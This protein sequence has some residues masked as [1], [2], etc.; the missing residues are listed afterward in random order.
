MNAHE[1]NKWGNAVELAGGAAGDAQ[2]AFTQL[3]DEAQKFFVTGER[4]PLINTLLQ[5]GVSL[6]D[7]NGQLRNQGEIF[8]ELADKTAKYGRQYQNFI[9]KQAGIS[10][11]EINYLAQSKQARE[12]NLRTAERANAVNEET[13]RKAQELQTYWR[14][15][16]IQIQAA[17]QMILTAIT[18][19]LTQVLKI[20]GDVNV[21]SEE[22]TTGLKL[23]GSAAV[24]IKN[25]FAGMGDAVGGAAA[26]IGAALHGNFSEASKILDDQAARS[27]ERN[28]KEASDLLDLWGGQ[29]AAQGGKTIS[30]SAAPATG[31]TFTP[32]PTS[33]AG[34]FNNPGN[35]MRNGQERQFSSLAEGED[36]LEHDLAAKMRRGLK[37][38]D[39]IIDAYEGGDN[40]HNNIPAYIADVKKRLGKN[41]L[42]E[43]DIKSLANAIA[44]HESP[45]VQSGPTPGLASAR[46]A[47]DRGG[48][49]SNVTVDIGT[50]NV[51]A[52]SADPRAVADQVPA[53]I[54]RK[55]S[56]TQADTGQS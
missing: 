45:G 47:I 31:G 22:F 8:E 20:F 46:G 50:M 3:T 24:V 54:Q 13:V 30:N 11:G 37:T 17:G 1:L 38:V 21:Q 33:K 35:L 28:E 55:F 39:T 12:D 43:G 7:S 15:I 40:V 48:G 32:S 53:A 2:A 6:K 18:P 29:T 9:L 42:S 4:S 56:V 27:K 52:P 44:M 51:N 19:T 34:R 14:N 5:Y 16:G 25:I 23:I 49:G 36:A 41:D 26:A 10:Q